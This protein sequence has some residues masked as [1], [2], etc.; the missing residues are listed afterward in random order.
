[1]EIVIP[2]WAVTLIG[3]FGSGLIGWLVYLSLN[4]FKLDK[5]MKLSEANDV[6]IMK[7]ISDLNVKMDRNREVFEDKLDK[8]REMFERKLDETKNDIHSTVGNLAD[9]F[10]KFL[11]T[12]MEFMQKSLVTQKRGN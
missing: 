10:D 1:M 7:D 3:V 4:S 12:Q 8:N 6:R 2:G 9:R 11:M 5:E